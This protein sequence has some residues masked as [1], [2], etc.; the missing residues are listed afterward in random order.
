MGGVGGLTEDVDSPRLYARDALAIGEGDLRLI[1]TIR[2]VLPPSDSQ[3]DR[4]SALRGRYGSE[5][6]KEEIDDCD[7]RCSTEGLF[8][9][10]ES[11]QCESEAG[12]IGERPDPPVIRVVELS[13]KGRGPECVRAGPLSGILKDARR[14]SLVADP[15]S[16]TGDAS[17]LRLIGDA[18]NTLSLTGRKKAGRGGG[19]YASDLSMTGRDPRLFSSAGLAGV[20]MAVSEMLRL[21]S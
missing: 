15:V 12:E 16:D 6:D 13:S 11:A 4:F 7:A 3:S 8:A 19:E 21:W 9:R 1:G 2:L 5:G 10:T 17:P 14:L 20:W 18:T